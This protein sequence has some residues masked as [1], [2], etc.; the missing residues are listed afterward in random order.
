MTFL[1]WVLA[2]LLMV[3][4]GIFFFFLKVHT[5]ASVLKHFLTL[6]N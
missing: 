6:E 2:D 5:E 4:S 1:H 3:P